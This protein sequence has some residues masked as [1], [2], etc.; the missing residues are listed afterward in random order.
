MLCCN[1]KTPLSPQQRNLSGTNPLSPC[2]VGQ[3]I[4][5]GSRDRI[6]ENLNL[7]VTQRGFEGHRHR[8][9]QV[10][11]AQEK[12]W[13]CVGGLAPDPDRQRRWVQINHGAPEILR[14]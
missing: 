13:G 6:A 9:R 14:P 1:D 11:L 10:G 4:L 12:A 5:R 7:D 8:S 2:A 3:E